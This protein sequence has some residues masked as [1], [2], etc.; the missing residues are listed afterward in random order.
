ML[1]LKKEE[2]RNNRAM[3]AFLHKYKSQCTTVLAI[4]VVY[5]VLFMLGITCPIKYLTGVSCPGCGMSRACFNALRLDFKSAFSY[6][7]LWFLLLPFAATVLVF[8][9]KKK[10]RALRITVTLG[11]L[12]MLAVYIL[13]LIMSENGVVVFEP[14]NGLAGRLFNKIFDFIK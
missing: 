10:R 6:H 12:L 4:I 11:A 9:L 13:R 1:Y 2:E 5:A 14:Q 3:R 7:P 8:F